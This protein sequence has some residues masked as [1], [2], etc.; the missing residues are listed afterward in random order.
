MQSVVKGWGV[1]LETVEVTE[2]QVLS[3]S[4][5]E[6]FQAPY[7]QISRLVAERARLEA[8]EQ[9]NA[10][11]VETDMKAR[12]SCRGPHRHSTERDNQAEPGFCS[13]V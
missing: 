6:N 3:S 10:L 13:S 9:I 4:P 11:Q 1:W 7:R 8:Q 2:V 5:F 12:S